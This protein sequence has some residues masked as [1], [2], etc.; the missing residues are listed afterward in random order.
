MLTLQTPY[1]LYLGDI[2]LLQSLKTAAG[3]AY[4]CPEK[5]VCVVMREGEASPFPELPAVSL[6]EARAI[7]AKSLILGATFPGG[8]LK[9]IYIADFIQAAQLGFDIVSGMHDKL[10]DIPELRAAAEEARVN[11][12]DVRHSYQKLP[13]GTGRKRT[14]RRLLTVGTDC[15]VGKKYTALA[16]TRALNAEGVKATFRATGQT[17]IMIAGEGVPLDAVPS[18]FISGAI[19]MLS[20]DNDLEHWDIIEGQGSLYHPAYAGV[21]L[22]LMHGSQPDVFVLCHDMSRTHLR[23]L[24]DVP[25][26]DMSVVIENT[27]EM[28]RVVNPHARCIGFSVN[29][30]S[31]SEGEARDYLKALSEKYHLPATDPVRFGVDSLIVNLLA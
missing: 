29:T 20:P 4:W 7:G 3:L 16:I 12:I 18:D 26:Q 27:V 31:V 17:G 10:S 5:C 30:S 23:H 8:G 21:T 11:L 9:D 19:E 25:V 24:P 15:V 1:A 22:G 13:V 28:L 2:T 14:G 6:E